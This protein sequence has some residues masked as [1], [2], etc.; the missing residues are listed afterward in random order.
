M[1]KPQTFM[2]NQQKSKMSR[3]DEY[4]LWA[5][6]REKEDHLEITGKSN[7]FSAILKQVSL[8]MPRPAF[9]QRV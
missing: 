6:L 5:L 4:R 1:F 9:R 2:Q 8:S 3:L 7:P